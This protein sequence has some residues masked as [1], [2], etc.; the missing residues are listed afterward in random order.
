MALKDIFRH[1]A[2]QTVGANEGSTPMAISMKDESRE[3]GD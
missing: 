3:I 1:M 2:G